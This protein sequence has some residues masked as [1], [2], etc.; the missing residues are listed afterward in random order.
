MN[1]SFQKIAAGIDPHSH[2]DRDWALMN[3]EIITEAYK[4]FRNALFKRNEI[5]DFTEH[6]LN[7]CFHAL[8][9]L[10]EYLLGKDNSM[11][12]SDAYIYEYYIRNRNEHF[13]TIAKEI[14]ESYQ[15]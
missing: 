2:G 14:D 1:Y 8:N 5:N 9:K 10:E 4:K 6:D 3:L 13:V 12:K 15:D 11:A 7:E